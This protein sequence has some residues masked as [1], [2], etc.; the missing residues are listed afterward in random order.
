MI[1]SVAQNMPNSLI[2]NVPR[3]AAVVLMDFDQAVN[4]S[5]FV[6]EHFPGGPACVPLIPP[7]PLHLGR[8]MGTRPDFP[9]Q[10][11]LTGELTAARLKGL[12]D[13]L[14]EWNF[15]HWSYVQKGR[16]LTSRSTLPMT[17]VVKRDGGKL[18]VMEFAG[19]ESAAQMRDVLGYA[20]SGACQLVA[21][22]NSCARSFAAVVMRA[23]AIS[24]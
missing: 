19:V 6:L 13:K 11:R 22:G 14:N 9:S 12:K 17:A 7:L 8:E 23:R 4:L 24:T 15:F 18:M 1:R 20:A 16:H 2:P 10:T 21:S 5:V 3:S